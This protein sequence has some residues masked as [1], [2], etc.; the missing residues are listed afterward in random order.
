MNAG[1]SKEAAVYATMGM[2]TINVFMTIVSMVLIEKAGRRTLHM[3]GLG[4][5]MSVTLL[6]TVCMALTNKA[7]WLSYVSVAC[8]FGYIIF[9]ATGPGSIPWFLV[10]ELFGQDARPIATSIAVAVN[11]TAN[12]VV[13]LTFLPITEVIGEYTFL[14]FVVLLAIFLVFTYKNVP[15]TK[16]KKIEEITAF[17]AEKDSTS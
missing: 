17:F 11:W 9:F 6:L 14:I 16:G 10:S 5:T 7:P 1:L 2:G 4:G 8:V 15:E 3:I 13:G 12:F